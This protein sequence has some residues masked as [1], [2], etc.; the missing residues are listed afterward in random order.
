MIFNEEEQETIHKMREI[1]FVAKQKFYILKYINT[2]EKSHP[3]RNLLC[4]ALFRNIILELY[5][6]LYD[7]TPNTIAKKIFDKLIPEIEKNNGMFNFEHKIPIHNIDD[8][9]V[10]TEIIHEELP[11]SIDNENFDGVNFNIQGI[12]SKFKKYRNKVLAHRD[13]G[14][15]DYHISQ[16]D[17]EMMINESEK[18]INALLKIIQPTTAYCFDVS[19]S[20]NDY[21]ITSL[22]DTLAGNKNVNSTLYQ[23]LI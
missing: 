13:Y 3:L 15:Y 19:L 17:I 1:F 20:V 6:I 2:T 21:Q 11:V 5:S 16:N 7:T 8:G 9:T 18:I 23:P 22:F 14:K 10:N 12:R 4:E